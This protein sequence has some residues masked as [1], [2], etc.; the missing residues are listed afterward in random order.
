[1][2]IMVHSKSNPHSW[3]GSDWFCRLQSFSYTCAPTIMV[4]YSSMVLWW[5]L[6]SILYSVHM[7]S[8][9]ALFLWNRTNDLFFTSFSHSFIST[10]CCSIFFF[11]VFVF[12]FFLLLL[13]TQC[14]TALTSNRCK[15]FRNLSRSIKADKMVRIYCRQ[16]V[17]I[18][19]TI[20]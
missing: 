2:A 11:V 7:C 15:H 10:N 8:F 13:Q 16:P 6:N 9:A 17:H 1:M 19:F 5:K 18:L 3:I 12:S 20:I 4:M 14:A